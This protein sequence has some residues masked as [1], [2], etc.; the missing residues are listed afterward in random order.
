LSATISIT[1]VE[2]LQTLR[3]TGIEV[4]LK[5]D[6]LACNAPK[7]ALTPKLRAE[8]GDRKLE[9]IQFLRQGQGIEMASTIPPLDRQGELPLSLAQERLW[10]L[11]RIN[12]TAAIYNVSSAFQL[13]GTLNL[14]LLQHSLTAI[15]HRHEILRARFP[16][17]E[18]KPHLELAAVEE[19]PLSVTTLEE[20]PPAPRQTQIHNWLSQE[21]SRPF[22]LSSDSLLRVSL[23][24]L[25]AEE[26]VLAVVVHHIVADGWSF[27]ILL[28]DL[29]AIYGVMLQ[30][31]DPT[32]PPLSIQYLDFAAWQHQKLDSEA[33]QKSLAYWQQHLQGELSPLQ[34]PRDRVPPPTPSHQGA[35]QS[36]TL[37]PSLTAALRE[38]SHREKV[39]PFMTLLAAFTALLNRY[40]A[41]EDLVF[42]LPVAGRNRRETQDLIGYFSN[43]LVLRADLA[44]NPSW[45]QLLQRV[46]QLIA[47]AYEHQNIPFGQVASLPSLA[48]LPLS[49]ALF[50]F[51]EFDEEMLKLPDIAVSPLT[52]DSGAADFD[53][54]LFVVDEGRQLQLIANYA[55]D[56]FSTAAIQ[57]LLE[58]Y[59][60]VLERLLDDPTQCLNTLPQWQIPE[61][62]VESESPESSYVPPNDELEYKLAQL[63]QQFLQVDRVGI[64][65][66]FFSLGGR[67]LVA[68][69]LSDAIEKELDE[70][71]PFA[72]LFQAPTIEQL[73]RVI[74]EDGWSPSW[75]N[76][77]PIQP[78][79][80]QTPLFLCQGV[81]I[82]SPL[83]P[84]LGLEQPIYGLVAVTESG[85]L[86]S[87]ES[88]EA[89]AAEY[90]E[91][92]LA[93]QPE[94]PYLL[95]GISYGGI[96]AFEMAQQL[97]AQGREVG[98][99][100]LLDT[101]IPGSEQPIPLKQRLAI[102][103]KQ[104]AKNPAY[105]LDK[106][107]KNV[108]DIGIKVKR[109]YGKAAVD[110]GVEIDGDLEY[111][112]M[113]EMNDRAAWDYVP[114]IY[115]GKLTLLKATDPE[116]L[117]MSGVP[118]DN[119]WEEFAGGGLDILEIP[120]THLGILEEPQVALLGKHLN[121]CLAQSSRA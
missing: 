79:G 20:L 52:I 31:Q 65:D 63:W 13:Q 40:S 82:Y 111:F 72:A 10:R 3:Q 41:Q 27:G 36:L 66:N 96:I 24:Q 44:G 87:Y 39:S 107:R 25:D 15:L 118:R 76:L 46:R 2:F 94:G 84:H 30:E 93:F 75:K 6:R 117:E 81:G 102:H 8:L 67:S 91:E 116:N 33:Y 103:L 74:R 112:A 50:N 64:R 104:F 57:T 48:H 101:I 95:G 83:I 26:W 77:A 22:D 4:R 54:S 23:L 38:L 89:L 55:T 34:L 5:G 85:E 110:A 17:K 21:A 9:I 37:S 70:E 105:A 47:D 56:L 29:G 80:S 115:P 61:Q 18:G 51:Q 69:E 113:Q 86:A 1:T 45:Q 58:N 59:Q 97:V 32:L 60:I 62:F 90:L 108:E 7:G 35:K 43:I 12:P 98:L 88:V 120:G 121:T 109:L 14:T 19:F 99:V 42:C 114:K 119:G 106:I 92:M 49:R 16:E 71:I 28:R 100:A 53:L 11:H 78:S 68:L 73:A